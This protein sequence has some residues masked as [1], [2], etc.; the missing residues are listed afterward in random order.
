M[1]NVSS[2]LENF[3]DV[4]NEVAKKLEVTMKRVPENQETM[5]LGTNIV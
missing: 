5:A 3:G 2:S 4:L 1:K